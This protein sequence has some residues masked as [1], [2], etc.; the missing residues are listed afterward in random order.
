MWS[1]CWG[2]LPILLFLF[3]GL[4]FLCKKKV[5]FF[6]I[7]TGLSGGF[8]NCILGLILPPLF[9]FRLQM[10][11]KYWNKTPK[12]IAEL[13]VCFTVLTIGVALFF[14]ST[15]FTIESFVVGTNTTIANV[16][17]GTA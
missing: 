11:L 5:P 1:R 15:I 10:K 16:T 3:L 7:I 6:H 12:K 8:G 9:Y 13:C 2:A 14:I 4:I 17:C